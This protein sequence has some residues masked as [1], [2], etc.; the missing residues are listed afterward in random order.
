MTFEDHI[1]DIAC[2]R[3]SGSI[4]YPT[5]NFVFENVPADLLEEVRR[6]SDPLVPSVGSNIFFI[7]TELSKLDSVNVESIL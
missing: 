3:P 5:D 2:L 7:G 6:S 4:S 1:Y